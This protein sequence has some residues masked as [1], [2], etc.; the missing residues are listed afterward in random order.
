MYFY[1]SSELTN[2]PPLKGLP[3]LIIGLMAIAVIR[4]GIGNSIIS[5]FPGV[6]FLI[7]T[8]KL[9]FESLFIH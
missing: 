2:V 8:A 1:P 7:D 4:G 9:A 5:Y 3:P 6:D